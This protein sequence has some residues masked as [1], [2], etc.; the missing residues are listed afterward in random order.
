[1]DFTFDIPESM[2]PQN[3]GLRVRFYKKSKENKTKTKE[4]GR[5]IHDLLDYMELQVPGDR[6]NIIHRP[7]KDEDKQRFAPQWKAYEAQQDQEQA[8]GTPLSVLG[9][10]A[11]NRIDD[12]RYQGIVTAEQFAAVTDDNLTKLG[13]I[14]RSER[15]KCQR[16]L[17]AAKSRAPM[18]KLEAQLDEKDKQIA[19]LRQQVTDFA[20][21]LASLEGKSLHL[22]ANVTAPMPI[23]EKPKRKYTRR[24]KTEEVASEG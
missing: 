20:A 12:L 1:M 9:L 19:T 15:E 16:I 23:T 22:P 6:T 13:P 3:Q 7:V 24:K 10:F 21:R 11:Q 5:P 8:S 18:L 4:A 2:L 17:E 14:A